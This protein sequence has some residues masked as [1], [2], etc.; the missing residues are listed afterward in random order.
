MS[1]GKK[2]SV[3]CPTRLV[4][5]TFLSCPSNEAWSGPF[6]FPSSKPGHSHWGTN[7]MTLYFPPCSWINFKKSNDTWKWEGMVP[8][9]VC[10]DCMFEDQDKES[11]Q[12]LRFPSFIRT[13]LQVAVP[14]HWLVFLE[15][16]VKSLCFTRWLCTYSVHLMSYALAFVWKCQIRRQAVLLPRLN[17]AVFHVG[18]L[19]GCWASTGL[20]LLGSW[21]AMRLQPEE[22]AS[23][24][25]NPEKLQLLTHMLTSTLWKQLFCF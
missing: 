21:R 9:L 3:V 19:C 14:G 11:A 22:T 8:L 23:P 16:W 5:S 10:F 13:A 17:A 12:A 6:L 20:L 7:W 1:Y 2:I 24:L 25:K 18:S 4:G 15:D